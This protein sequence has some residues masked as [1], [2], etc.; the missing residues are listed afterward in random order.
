MPSAHSIPGRLRLICVG[1]AAAA[2]LLAPRASAQAPP[3]HAADSTVAIVN[4]SAAIRVWTA[5]RARN[6]EPLYAA[7]AR[8]DN[9]E[10]VVITGTPTEGW[11]L[12]SWG[13]AAVDQSIL[14]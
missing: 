6:I 5:A 10:T 11:L 7:R 12:E 8:L 4:H 1:A 9:A 3:D 2:A 14:R 13:G